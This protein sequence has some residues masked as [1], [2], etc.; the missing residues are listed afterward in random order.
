VIR[1]EGGR[2][3]QSIRA[4]AIQTG[5]ASTD[6]DAELDKA[7][8]LI[9]SI[10]PAPDLVVLPELFARP[11][12][13]VGLN[14]A[15]YLDWAEPIDG[16]TVSRLAAV[17]KSLGCYVVAPFF[18]RGDVP[19]PAWNSAALIGR[20]GA[21][22]SGRLP[23]GRSVGTYRKNA[24]SAYS[25]DGHR[26]DET[27]YFRAG[28]GF[29]VFDTDF[30]PLGILIC[31][32]RWYPEAWRVL[33]LQGAVVVAVPN[34]SEGYVSDMF[35]PLIRT[36][37]AQNVLFGIGVNR[38]GVESFQG[39]D[40]RYYGRSCISGPRGDL[41][42]EAEEAAPDQVAVAELDLGR[43]VADRRRLWVYRDRRPELY[44]LLAERAPK[45]ATAPTSSADATHNPE[46][47]A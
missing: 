20:D 38:G 12:W 23:D 3:K 45:A 14:D 19:G 41:L 13:C 18:E 44:G 22:I 9:R 43:I 4:A 6:L 24:I 46:R 31:Y 8:R 16:P 21:V 47:A 29:P 2:A 42:A 36:S 1:A 15:S 26:N 28:D 11:F 30:G 34:A 7:E 37:S 32:D 27:F 39:V 40:T 10:D 33:A 17:A 5:P 25:W 35:Q